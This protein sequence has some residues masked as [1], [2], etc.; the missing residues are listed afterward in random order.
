[1][2]VAVA[3]ESTLINELMDLFN[4]VINLLLEPGKLRPLSGWLS[5]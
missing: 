1:M 5:K 2:E 3:E 4:M